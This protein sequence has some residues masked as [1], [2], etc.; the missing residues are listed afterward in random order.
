M[1]TE[2]EQVL[3]LLQNDEWDLLITDFQMPKMDGMML[4]EQVRLTQ[5]ALPI[6]IITGYSELISPQAI[7]T[8]SLN[9]ILDKPVKLTKIR[10]V[11]SDL[12]R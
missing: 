3:H 9:Y 12:L 7:K 1:A 8:L 5:P 2:G 10:S 11:V 4:A 6:M